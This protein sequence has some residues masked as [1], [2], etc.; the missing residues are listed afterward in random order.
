MIIKLILKYIYYGQKTNNTEFSQ[1]FIDLIWIKYLE[2]KT[3]K[4][5]AEKFHKKLLQIIGTP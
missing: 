5:N 3:S 1:T 2:D 4:I